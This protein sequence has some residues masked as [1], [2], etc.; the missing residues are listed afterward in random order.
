MMPYGN[1]RLELMSVIDNRA[2]ISPLNFW[3]ITP[4]GIILVNIGS[5][6][7]MAPKMQSYCWQAILT[8]DNQTLIM[9]S[10]KAILIHINIFK[11]EF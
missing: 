8:F 4:Y 9:N 7:G 1:I 10:Q 2:D 3:L 11:G 6:N 5:G